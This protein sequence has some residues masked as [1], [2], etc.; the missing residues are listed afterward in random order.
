MHSVIWKM[1]LFIVS[2]SVNMDISICYEHFWCLFLQIWTRTEGNSLSRQTSG[3][4]SW[5]GAPVGVCHASTTLTLPVW[6][7]AGDPWSIRPCVTDAQT[8]LTAQS[9][10]WCLNK[11]YWTKPW[12]SVPKE[13][14]YKECL[15]KGGWVWRT[16][17][18]VDYYVQYGTLCSMVLTWKW[19]ECWRI[20]KAPALLYME[21]TVYLVHFSFFIYILV[22]DSCHTNSLH[23]KSTKYFACGPIPL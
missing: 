13:K 6:V 19:R 3:P 23:F 2:S 15:W 18:N 12:E 5:R 4:R 16:R 1:Y 22:L 8:A 11:Q 14:P 20:H 17:V 10:S 7:G 21:L 9:H